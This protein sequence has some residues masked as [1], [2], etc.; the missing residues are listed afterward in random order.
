MWCFH[1]FVRFYRTS[2]A[3]IPTFHPAPPS[4]S[5]SLSLSPSLSLSLSLSLTQTLP[6]TRSASEQ[7][8]MYEARHVFIIRYKSLLKQDSDPY[9]LRQSV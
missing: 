6:S 8:V 1:Y 2:S 3:S 5:L 7:T 9:S 4:L